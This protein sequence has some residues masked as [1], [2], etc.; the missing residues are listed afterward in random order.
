MDKKIVIFGAG[1]TGVRALK[2]YGFDKVAFW[3]DNNKEKHGKQL[4][5]IT[6]YSVEAALPELE[7]YHIVIASQAQ[8]TMEEQLQELGLTD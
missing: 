4:K 6:I 3:I 1:E 7:K 2:K 8:T 5:G